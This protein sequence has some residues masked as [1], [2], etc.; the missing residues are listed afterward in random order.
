MP[1]S[2]PPDPAAPDDSPALERAWSLL[3]A[4]AA[5][6]IRQ[7]RARSA[8]VLGAVAAVPLAAFAA[9]SSAVAFPPA[10]S[11]SA[12]AAALAAPGLG[13]L[14]GRF[15]PLAPALVHARIDR[16]FGLADEALAAR[17]LAGLTSPAWR[18]AI[19]R[20]AV[21][22][23]GSADWRTV[24]PVRWPRRAGLA[25]AAALLAAVLAVFLLPRAPSVSAN[26]AA[27]LRAAQQTA[28]AELAKT[29]EKTADDKKGEEWNAFRE[30][31]AE[32][33]A[34]LADPSLSE[35]ELLVAL[36]RVESRLAAASA[37]LAEAGVSNH[38]ED[39]AD[40]LA[41]IEGMEAAAK[42]LKDKNLSAAADA[43][44][45]ASKAL[46]E[47]DAKASFKDGTGAESAKRLAQLADK[48]AKK[49][50]SKLAESAK[51]MSKAAEAKDAKSL[52][53]CSS[54]LAR[55]SREAAANDAA[56]SAASSVARSLADARSALSE[57][58]TPGQGDDPLQLAG[59]A[60]GSTPGRSASSQSGPP[61]N[62]IGSAAGDHSPGA[63]NALDAAT[64]KESLTGTANA[65]G[66][67][68]KRTVRA[69]EAAPT[70]ASKAT[71]ADLAEFTRLSRE[72]VEDESLPLE[73]RRSIHRYFQ[74]I[75]PSSNDTAAASSS[76]PPP[77]S[78]N[79]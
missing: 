43:L 54:S 27:A 65:D 12:L 68:T 20:Q 75:R 31:V 78:T 18:A 70:L 40:A 32:L 55:Q 8:F 5:L 9:A 67:S 26:P 29:W 34:K 72:A 45:K 48:A 77:V 49:G 19:L 47:K 64:R 33:Q 56:R 41:G 30:T 79:P 37:S 61:G 44:D 59:T 15:R 62:G 60:P 1:Q 17:E 35:R 38:S 69:S 39:L 7:N 14:A 25:T 23:T 66:E 50:D 10:L 16:Q 57:G 36:A 21:A 22:H 28:L 13:W 4:R 6:R 63:E 71:V 51:E 76:T 46:S 2:P 58:R 42:A 24:W 52:G 53:Q 73:H 74:L 11:I 3:V